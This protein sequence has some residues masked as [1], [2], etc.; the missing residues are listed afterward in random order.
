MTSPNHVICRVVLTVVVLWATVGSARYLL[1][2]SQG[3]QEDQ[4]SPSKQSD[5]AKQDQQDIP[6]KQGN[7]GKQDKNDNAKGKNGTPG[8]VTVTVLGDQQTPIKDAVVVLFFDIAQER[9]TTG[10]DGKV[11]FQVRRGPL[12]LRITADHMEPYQ[13]PLQLS[14]DQRDSALRVVLNKSD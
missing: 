3:K 2:Q 7:G 8:T 5:A 10:S 4:A 9:K 1:G 13:K 12:T 11:V 14:G 6:D